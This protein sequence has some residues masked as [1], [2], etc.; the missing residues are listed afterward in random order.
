MEVMSKMKKEDFF[1]LKIGMDIYLNNVKMKIIG[2]HTYPDQNSIVL[3]SDIGKRNL[4]CWD[5][6][7]SK[8]HLEKTK[9]KIKYYQW[10]VKNLNGNWR[11]ED[12]YLNDELEDSSGRVFNFS[13]KIKIEDEFIE[14]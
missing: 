12:V 1:E 4:F 7:H 5:E 2:L 6:L 11:R 3:E 8:F 14:I 13:E 9:K 10:I